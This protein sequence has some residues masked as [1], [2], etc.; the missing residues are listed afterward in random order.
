MFL[1]W[2]VCLLSSYQKEEG[3]SYNHMTERCER[4]KY[5]FGGSVHLILLFVF[6]FCFYD[7]TNPM[8][9]D[10]SFFFPNRRS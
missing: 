8:V 2:L 1:C 6:L 9:V 10:V 3:I 7:T 4:A 5:E